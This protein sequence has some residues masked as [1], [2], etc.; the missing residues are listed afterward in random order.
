ML[1]MKRVAGTPWKSLLAAEHTDFAA[2]KPGDA[3]EQHLRV[4]MQVCNAVHY[5]HSKGIVHRDLKPENVMVGGFGEV[6]VLDW[7]IALQ[8]GTDT[9][10]GIAGAPAF[11]APEMLAPG[12]EPVTPRSDVY[13]L[14]GLLHALL[15]GRPRHE[16]DDL[17]AVLYAAWQSEPA[18]YDAEV[19]SELAALANRATA[20]DPA[21]RPPSALAFRFRIEEF[22]RHRESLRLEREARARL[23]DLESVVAGVLADD[24]QADAVDEE[25]GALVQQLGAEARFGFQQAAR[26]WDGN[27][28]ARGGEQ[29]VVVALARF[30]IAEG[31]ARTA[32]HLVAGLDQPPQGLVDALHALESAKVASQAAQARLQRMERELDFD[33]GSDVRSQFA[34]AAGIVWAVLPAAFGILQ[35]LGLYEPTHAGFFF[36]GLFFVGFLGAGIW[37]GRADLLANRI[38]RAFVRSL[39]AGAATTL[40]VRGVVWLQ[41]VPVAHALAYDMVVLFLLFGAMAAM[42]DKR[43]AVVTGVYAAGA[44]LASVHADSALFVTGGANLVG[45]SGVAL[46]WSPRSRCESKR[47]RLVRHIQDVR[48]CIGEAAWKGLKAAT[49]PVVRA[50]IQRGESAA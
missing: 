27:A 50:A 32:G 46:V 14:G 13:L 24:L 18:I 7:G 42:I 30:A 5:A 36:S 47:T 28:A 34:L 6:Y 10:T 21:L 20:K 37:L 12:Q 8:L 45:M 16:G 11:M 48:G 19:P 44:L 3:L 1:V 35:R 23:L 39:V 17:Y 40:L 15:T 25:T 49:G 41:D 43:L 22:L 33:T 4:L 38:N 9:P 29:A 26:A 2:E 31:D